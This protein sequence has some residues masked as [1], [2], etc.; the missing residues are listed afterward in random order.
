MFLLSTNFCSIE[1][2]KCLANFG[3]VSEKVRNHRRPPES[4]RKK[5]IGPLKMLSRPKTIWFGL[6]PWLQHL[7]TRKKE[8][9][10]HTQLHPKCDQI[11]QNFKE[12][13][14]YLK[15][16]KEGRANIQIKTRCSLFV[17]KKNRLWKVFLRSRNRWNLNGF[18]IHILEQGTNTHYV[19]TELLAASLDSL[20][21]NFRLE[22]QKWWGINCDEMSLFWPSQFSRTTEQ[23]E[24][25]G[26]SA[27]WSAIMG[28]N[29]IYLHAYTLHAVSPHD[30][31]SFVHWNGLELIF[32]S[33]INW[34]A[35]YFWCVECF[36]FLIQMQNRN[37]HVS[38]LDFLSFSSC[39]GRWANLNKK[40][41]PGLKSQK[42]K[43]NK[44]GRTIV[45]NYRAFS[46][47]INMSMESTRCGCGKNPSK[48]DC[49]C[50]DLSPHSIILRACVCVTIFKN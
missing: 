46:L 36:S 25:K 19:P 44:R 27:L 43:T 31:A 24:Q 6:R 14:N 5:S 10:W 2:W 49:I 40:L 3:N 11:A 18:E 34:I 21:Q 45:A 39:V 26:R 30:G 28:L 7:L 48:L 8:N 29:P 22:W 33:K 32:I 20:A 12:K 47:R 1:Q 4:F 23:R 9:N 37:A 17:I 35:C 38:T 16:K 50:R 13:K 42:E 41:L 15:E